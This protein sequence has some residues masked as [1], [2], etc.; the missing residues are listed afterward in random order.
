MRRHGH[1]RLRRHPNDSQG[2]ADSAQIEYI[3]LNDIDR[4]HP[5]HPSPDSKIAVLLASRHIDRQRVRHLFR[6]LK[7]PIGARFFVVAI[8]PVFQHSTNL[9]RPVRLEAGIRVSQQVDVRA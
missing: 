9:Y 7:F 3:G 1:A 4:A 6:L 2:S 5:Y 8:P